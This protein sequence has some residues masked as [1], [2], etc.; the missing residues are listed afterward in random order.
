MSVKGKDLMHKQKIR[1]IH[2]TLLMLI[3]ASPSDAFLVKMHLEGLEYKQMA[4]R[5]LGN[6]PYSQRELKKKTIIP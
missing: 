6:K 4:E 1:L 3:D 2:E 5:D